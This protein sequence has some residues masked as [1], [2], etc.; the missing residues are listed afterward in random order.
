MAENKILRSEFDDANYDRG[1]MDDFARADR[2]SVSAAILL[3]ACQIAKLRMTL[4]HIENFRRAT[5]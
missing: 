3:L 4:I 2:A 1:R 5:K